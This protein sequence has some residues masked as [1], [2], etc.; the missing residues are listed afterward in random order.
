MDM[1]KGYN[2]TINATVNSIN[3]KLLT[4]L[5]GEALMSMLGYEIVT[6]FLFMGAQ[7]PLMQ[8]LDSKSF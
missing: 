4:D 3:T 6:C 2:G 1:G 5:L 8:I 7:S